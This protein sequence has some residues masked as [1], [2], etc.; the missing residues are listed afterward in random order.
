MVVIVVDF[1]LY[2]NF[3]WF[4]VNHEYNML[5]HEFLAKI[6]SYSISAYDFLA[7]VSLFVFQKGET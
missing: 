1:I 5:I 7:V 2:T 4:M 6:F 3:T